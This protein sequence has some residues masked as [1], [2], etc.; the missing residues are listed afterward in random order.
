MRINNFFKLVIAVGVS[1]G[2]EIIGSIFTAPAVQ[3]SWYA[4]IVKPALNPPSWVFGPVWTTL[5]AL[6]G[7]AAFLVWSSYAKS[8]KDK[9]KGIRVALI[10]FG[11]QLVLNT[12]WSIIFF[13]LH[14][15][16][17]A[18]IEIVFLWLAILA[19]IIAFAK[20][21]KPAAWL[22]VPYI[23]WVS[24]AMY[25]NYAIWALN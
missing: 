16:G 5:F 7:I 18:L 21:S 11:V 1:L 24:F 3:S 10:L 9:K 13:G 17:G 23:A 2:A 22:L 4:E 25:L 6:M 14:S 8:T 12:L 19:T 15:P 20:I